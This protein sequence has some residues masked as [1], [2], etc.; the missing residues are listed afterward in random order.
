MA[1]EF[2]F[3]LALQALNSQGQ[4]ILGENWADFLLDLR[5]ALAVKGKEDPA[6]TEGLLLFYFAQPEIAC[7]TLRES[8]TRL[9]KVYEWKENVGPLP[10]RIV[11]H[12][13]KAG[14]PPGPAHDPSASFWD[15]LQ[16]E[17]PYVTSLLKI[18]RAHV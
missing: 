16:H 6:S 14:D 17:Q 18:G 10:L 1:A 9:K 7:V 15:L 5:Q 11:L 3:L 4:A 12:L 13:E 2:T 8:L